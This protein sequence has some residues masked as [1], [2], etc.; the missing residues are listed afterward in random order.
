MMRCWLSRPCAAFVF[1][2]VLGTCAEAEPSLGAIR[3]RG[4][5]RIGIKGDAPPFGS[6]DRHG[7]PVGF[8]TV[9]SFAQAAWIPRITIWRDD[10]TTQRRKG[11]PCE[12][13]APAIATS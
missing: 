6:L 5:I 4:L 7:R 10:G 13:W 2:L 11:E 3:T 8:E 12:S 1:V 9:Y